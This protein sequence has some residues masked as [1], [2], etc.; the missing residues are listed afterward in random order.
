MAKRKMYVVKSVFTK[1]WW[2]PEESK[3]NIVL[4]TPCKEYAEAEAK[5]INQY[6]WDEAWVEEE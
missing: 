4:R 5:R 1:Y 6:P 3:E 2:D